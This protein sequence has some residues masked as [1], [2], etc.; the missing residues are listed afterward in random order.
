MKA[1]EDVP[2]QLVDIKITEKLNTKIDLNLTFVDESGRTVALSE[3]FNK[4]R[5]VV[6]NLVYY[7]CPMLCGLVLKGVTNGLKQIPGN[8]GIDFEVI[9]ISIDPKETS[10]LAAAKKDAVLTDYGRPNAGTG[11]HFLIGQEANI[12]AIADQVG[13]GYRYDE[14]QQ[15]YAHAAVT[16]LLT[17]DARISRYLYGLEYQPRDLRLGLTEAA[18]GKYGSTIDKFLLFC[19]HYD[20]KAGSYVFFATNVMKAGGVL[21]ILILAFVLVNLWRQDRDRVG[22]TKEGLTRA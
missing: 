18:E 12:K 1:S 7:G 6:F 10:S 16:M 4:G 20:A 8:P 13:F 2:P 22:R 3:Y 11:W 5:P 19:F 9:T 21:T 15:Q 14:K 17:S